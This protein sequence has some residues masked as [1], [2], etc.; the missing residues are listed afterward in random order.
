MKPYPTEDLLHIYSH[1]Q[2]IIEKLRNKSLLIT[3]GT[4]FLGANFLKYFSYLNDEHNMN[5]DVTVLTR[6]PDKFIAKFPHLSQKV[7]LLKGNIIN[8]DWM[9]D[10]PDYNY[11]IHGA[12]DNDWTN[13]FAVIQTIADG[14]TNALDFATTHGCEK[15]LMISSGIASKYNS[16]MIASSSYGIAKHLAEHICELQHSILGLNTKICRLYCSVGPYLSLNK[17]FAIGNFIGDAINNRDIHVKNG[18]PRRSYIYSADAIIWMLKILIDGNSGISYSVGS[19][20]DISI[21]KL[22]EKV[23]D[24]CNPNL[25]IIE[26][27]A[28]TYDYYVPN[29]NDID[30]METDFGLKTWIDLDEAIKR[31]FYWNKED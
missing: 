30:L 17:H 2:D 31:T 29:F 5:L 3:G 12:C 8:K 14:T 18:H 23:R 7:T 25:K 16:P 13:N 27:P 20:E 6:N 21:L 4:G 26:D 10:Q 11:I 15:F 9:I 1:T 24:I 28:S 22:A 19:N